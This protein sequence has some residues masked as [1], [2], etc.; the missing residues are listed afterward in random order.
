MGKYKFTIIS[1][2]IIIVAAIPL[3]LLSKKTPS[4]PPTTTTVVTSPSPEPLTPDNA[5]ETLQKADTSIQSALDQTSTDL[6][7]VSQIDSS[8]DSTT[9][10]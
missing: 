10:L 6:N 7:A 9:G 2:I 4:T 8:Q 5:D 3:Y 1:L